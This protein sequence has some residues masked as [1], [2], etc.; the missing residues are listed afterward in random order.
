MNHLTYIILIFSIPSLLLIYCNDEIIEDSSSKRLT[1]LWN[2]QMMSECELGYSAIIYNNYGCWCGVGGS[3]TPVDEI[4]ECCE[5]HDKCYDAAIDAKICFDVPYEYL[6]D[7]TWSCINKSAICSPSL[8]GCGKSL[9][10]CDKAVV[11]CW[12]K[13]GKPN[14]KPVCKKGKYFGY[15]KENR[16]VMEFFKDFY[17]ELFN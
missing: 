4:D 3:G 1:A 14:K 9:C 5:H 12:K 17:N 11:N 13:Y 15:G 7:Y 6:D 8:T 2:L 10:D 16:S